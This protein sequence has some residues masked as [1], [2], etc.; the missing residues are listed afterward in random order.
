MKKKTNKFW[1]FSPLQDDFVVIFVSNDYASLIQT[2][3]K[4]EFLTTLSKRYKDK[5]G[6]DLR[7][8][9]NDS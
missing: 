5:C 2:V 6:R 7:L 3:L 4:T 1:I 8:Y 9:F